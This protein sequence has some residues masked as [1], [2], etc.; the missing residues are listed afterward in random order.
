MGGLA[1]G[2]QDRLLKQDARDATNNH[3]RTSVPAGIRIVLQMYWHG[4]Q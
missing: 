4:K 1:G 2:R 3:L